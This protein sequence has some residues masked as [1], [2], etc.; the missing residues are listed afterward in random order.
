MTEVQGLAGVLFLCAA[1]PRRCPLYVLFR[2]CILP[3]AARQPCQN[4][5]Y[6]PPSIPMVFP[7]IHPAA[8]EARKH[9]TLAI[10]SGTPTLP[11]GDIQAARCVVCNASE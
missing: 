4:Y 3:T 10:S 5:L 8:S 7:V 6:A 2:A 9:T 11:N 1:T